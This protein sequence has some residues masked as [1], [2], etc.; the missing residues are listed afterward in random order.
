MHRIAIA[1]AVLMTAGTAAASDKDDAF[2]QVKQFIDGFNKGDAKSA[3]ATCASP[4]SIVDEFPPYAWQGANACADWAGD[5]EA[6]AKKNAITDSV[7]TLHKPRHVEVSG[8]RA[9]VVVPADYAY[10]VK[11]KKASQKGSVMAA[12]LKKG[13]DGWRITGWSWATR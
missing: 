5:F 6:N 7:V 3:L 4:V 8:D 1:L 12:A 10:K 2:A 11:G 13:P 9:Y